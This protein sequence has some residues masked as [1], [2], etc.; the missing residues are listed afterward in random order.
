MKR[1]GRPARRATYRRYD[2]AVTSLLWPV[3]DRAHRA[4]SRRRAL[5]QAETHAI[6]GPRV[7]SGSIVAALMLVSVWAGFSDTFYV[8]APIVTGNSRV[9]APTIVAGS[10]IAGMHVMWLNARQV[11]TAML[12]AVPQLQSAQLACELPANCSIAVS[13]REPLLAWRWGQAAVWIDREGVAFPAQGDVPGLLTIASTEAPAPLPGRKL[14]Q[15]LMSAI[16]SLASELPKVRRYHYSTER[17]LEFQDE[18][19]YPVYLGTGA[20]MAD[21]VAVW[22]ALG[23]NLAARRITPKYIDV[24]FPLAP[25]YER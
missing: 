14:D 11:E 25:Y 23:D 5:R 8:R 18:R 9:P 3:S 21:R 22:R 2:Q 6:L 7:L 20:N 16:V 1:R 4:P 13:E 15:K 24:R 17:G 12:R 19:S 10:G